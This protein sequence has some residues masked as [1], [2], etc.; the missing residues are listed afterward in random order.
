MLIEKVVYTLA[1][2]LF[3]YLVYKKYAKKQSFAY[4]DSYA[5][6]RGLIQKFKVI[7][8]ELDDEQVKEVALA[9]KDYFKIAKMANQ[10]LV[11]M[12]SQVVDDL[13]HEFILFTRQYQNFCKEAFSH[14]LHHTPAE[15]MQTKSM[16]TEGIKRTWKYACKLEGIDPKAP[17]YLPRLFAMDALYG[18]ENGFYYSKDCKNSNGTGYCASDIGCFGGSGCAGDTGSSCGSSCSSGCGGD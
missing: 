12:P 16:P 17:Q 18:I 6:H 4:I 1:V 2:L 14:Y 13:W 9:L 3:I 11:S 15:A 8:P 7:R 5:F 10:K